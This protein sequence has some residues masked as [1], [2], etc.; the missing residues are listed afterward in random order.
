MSKKTENIYKSI[1]RLE[2]LKN[3]ISIIAKLAKNDANFDESESENGKS[4]RIRH[5]ENVEFEIGQELKSLKF[6]IDSLYL[7]NGKSTS[8]AKQNAS[9]ENGKKGGRPP[10]EITEARRKIRDLEENLIPEMEKQKN[11]A[12]DAD[13]E[14]KLDAEIE[15]ANAELGELR[16]KVGKW[17]NRNQRKL[18]RE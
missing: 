13:E 18:R 15:K 14:A 9:K 2:D 12:L 6:W 3:E 16:E 7:Y 10:K 4:G 17:E 11:L 1:A 8:R 5:L